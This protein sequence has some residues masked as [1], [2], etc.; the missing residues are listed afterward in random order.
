MDE[1]KQGGG[2]PHTGEPPA[3]PQGPD[4]EGAHVDDFVYNPPNSTSVETPLVVPEPP[5][6]PASA[7]AVVPPNTP[8]KPPPPKSPSLFDDDDDDDEGMLRM[9]FLE[10]LEE[11]RSRIIRILM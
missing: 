3:V 2:P 7:V 4:K 11:L 10:H 1:E 8:A 9:S 6:K 5:V